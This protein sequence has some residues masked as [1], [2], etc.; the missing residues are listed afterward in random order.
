MSGITVSRDVAAPVD[1]V[2]AVITDL[3]ASAARISAIDKVE[4]LTDGP[5][6]VGTRWRE[7]RTMFGKQATEEMSVS[8]IDPGRSYT[9]V[10][11][12]HGAHYES[13]F[14]VE[15][16]DAG[17]RLTM[18]FDGQATSAVGKVMSALTGWIFKGA[19]TKAL[20]KDLDEI[21]AA[22]EAGVSS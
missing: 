5:F 19:T 2:W 12:S 7:T 17:S 1:A 15:P 4:V 3:E 9:V 22:A 6:A 10:A 11:D 18:T 16:T 14:I 8:A 21:A 20:A 13:A